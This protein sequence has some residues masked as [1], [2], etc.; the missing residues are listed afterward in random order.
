[1]LA[2]K[3]GLEDI[4]GLFRVPSAHLYYCIVELSHSKPSFLAICL[5]F[6]KFLLYLSLLVSQYFQLII[7]AFRL[8]G[9]LSDLCVLCPELIFVNCS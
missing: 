3:R 4:D 1:M 5:S 6:G 9:R 7:E 8:K 2:I